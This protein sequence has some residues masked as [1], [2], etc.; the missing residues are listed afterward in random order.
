LKATLGVPIPI[1]HRIS[2]VSELSV[3]LVRKFGA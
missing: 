3:V 1:R 2:L